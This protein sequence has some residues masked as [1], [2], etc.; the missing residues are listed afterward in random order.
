MTEQILKTE[1]HD[2]S[3]KIYELQNKTE[4]LT[5]GQGYAVVSEIE[6]NTQLLRN[7][8]RHLEHELYSK[9][10]NDKIIES[11]IELLE[12]QISELENIK[13]D[14]VARINTET[15]HTRQE[16]NEKIISFMSQELTPIKES[17]ENNKK[18]IQGIKDEIGSLRLEIK[19]HEKNQEI[20]DAARFDKFKIILT[21]VV[22][23]IGAVSTLSLL[24]EPAI[25]T[26]VQIFFSL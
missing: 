9:K 10:S 25:R 18:E 5:N 23:V 13:F 19:E 11:N 14:L 22:A 8:L 6:K 15:E 26:L 24:L 21:A 17:I 12:K 2:M 4:H 1:I 16:L 3:K 20:K 7:D